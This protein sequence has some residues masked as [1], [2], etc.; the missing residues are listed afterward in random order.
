M[1]PPIAL[2]V[3]QVELWPYEPPRDA[4]AISRIVARIWSGGADALMEDRFGPIGGQPWD[5][6]QSQSILNYL[7][8]PNC[9]AFVAVEW[10]EVIGFC[11]YVLEPDRRLGTVGYNGVDPDHQSRKIGSAMMTFVMDQFHKEKMQ[12]AAVIVATNQQHAPARRV[13]EK[14]GFEP[15]M[16]LEYRVRKL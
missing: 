15:V 3:G 2:N 1:I 13:Y 16:G 5:H 4:Q 9:R 11:S 7:A 14:H 10:D 6:W 12:F 8:A